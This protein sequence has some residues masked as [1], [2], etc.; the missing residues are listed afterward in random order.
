MRCQLQCCTLVLLKQFCMEVHCSQLRSADGPISQN[1]NTEFIEEAN[2]EEANKDVAS[3][4]C[5]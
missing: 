4:T 2:K 3:V 5:Q 1:V